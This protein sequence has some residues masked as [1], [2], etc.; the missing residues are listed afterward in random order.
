MATGFLPLAR[1][2]FEGP[3][4]TRPRRFSEEEALLDLLLRAAYQPVDCP[5]GRSSIRLRRGELFTTERQTATRW[6]WSQAAVHRYLG[7][8]EERGDIKTRTANRYGTVYLI[9]IYETY[10]STGSK[11]ESPGE[12]KAVRKRI[13]SESEVNRKRFGSESLLKKEDGKSMRAGKDLEKS[14]TATS[15]RTRDEAEVERAA[16]EA[17]LVQGAHEE[18]DLTRAETAELLASLREGTP[19]AEIAERRERYAN[20]A[21]RPTF[22]S[23][24]H[25]RNRVVAA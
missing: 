2:F 7:A 22:D 18:G 24:Q 14:T 15:V 16:E 5:A 11:A 20:Q 12:S 6:G 3:L 21:G 25:F 4:W 19:A 9:V 1:E 13:G 10:C 8:L 23:L 17:V